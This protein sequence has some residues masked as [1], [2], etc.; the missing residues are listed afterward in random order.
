MPSIQRELGF[1]LGAGKVVE[2]GEF[3]NFSGA[4]PLNDVVTTLLI[5]V[6]DYNVGDVIA[7]R[8]TSL[9]S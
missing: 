5:F 3:D 7:E 1:R 4:D 8:E 9:A 2:L 6:V